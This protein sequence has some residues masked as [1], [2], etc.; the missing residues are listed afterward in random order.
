MF[1]FIIIVPYCTI[2]L[3][4]YYSGHHIQDGMTRVCAIATSRVVMPCIIMYTKYYILGIFK[5]EDAS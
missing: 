5:K 1:T 2:V 4:S 3:C